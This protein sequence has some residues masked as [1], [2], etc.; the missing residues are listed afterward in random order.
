[1]SLLQWVKQASWQQ[2]QLDFVGL[3]RALTAGK[4]SSECVAKLALGGSTVTPS[5]MSCCDLCQLPSIAG[6]K[7]A[8]KQHI[9][10]ASVAE[11]WLSIS[12]MWWQ[13]KSWYIAFCSGYVSETWVEQQEGYWLCNATAFPLVAVP[14]SFIFAT[15]DLPRAIFHWV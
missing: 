4:I 14:N 1:M 10:R 13:Q 3:V 7:T 6:R 15:S 12:W 5:P 8:T 2:V 11:R 9:C